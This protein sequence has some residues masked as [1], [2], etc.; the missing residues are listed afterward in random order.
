MPPNN[1]GEIVGMVKLKRNGKNRKS[2][3]RIVET[4]IDVKKFKEYLFSNY[5]EMCHDYCWSCLVCR[6]WR[7]FE[8]LEGFVKHDI[9]LNDE[10]MLPPPKSKH[11][12]L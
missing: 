3:N 9:E 8:A 12:E 6:V 2:D 11:Y 4:G 10:E 1:K 7:V 5:G